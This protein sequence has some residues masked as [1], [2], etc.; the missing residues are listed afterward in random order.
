MMNDNQY[1]ITCCS[2]AEVIKDAWIETTHPEPD[3]P[4]ARLHSLRSDHLFV[5]GGLYHHTLQVETMG[6]SSGGVVIRSSP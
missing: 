3:K 1:N 2:H 6:W 5:N 4:F